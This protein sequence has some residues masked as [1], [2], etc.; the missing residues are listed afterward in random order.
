MIVL[1]AIVTWTRRATYRVRRDY[2]CSLKIDNEF[3]SLIPPLTTEE[4]NG[5]E[6]DIINRGCRIPLDSWGDIVVDGHNRYEICEKHNLPFETKQIEFESKDEAKIWIIG[7][8]LR[9]RNLVPF[10]KIELKL[11]SEEIQNRIDISKDKQ[12]SGLKQFQTNET[13]FQTSEKRDEPINTTKEIAESV[14]VSIDTASKA[15]LVIAKAPEE[16]KQ[17]IREGDLTIN[18]AYTYIKRQEIQEKAKEVE[19]PKGKYRI[20]YAD[21]AWQY[22]DKRDGNT[23]GAEDHY[24]TMSIDELCE[25]PIKE[26]SEDNSVLFLWV[27]SPLLE[28]CFKIIK[29][30]GFQYKTSFVWDKIKHNMGHYNS[31]RHE[32]LLIATKGSCLPDNKKLYDS[33]QAI[34]RTDTHSEKPEEFRN[35]IDD[36]YTYGNRIELF[37]RTKHENWDV[38]G[39]EV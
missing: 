33:V 6:Q 30:W 23:T 29:A 4:Y 13:V 1:Q 39:N 27:T 31:V 26:I 8:Q 24:P 22:A 11:K 20:I 12:L 14:G 34:E 32:F 5:L 21:P 9:R 10:V 19:P 17:S 16:V 37:S 15:K 18:K 2:M 38:W 28:A 35:I 3:K 36:I 7:N 25:L